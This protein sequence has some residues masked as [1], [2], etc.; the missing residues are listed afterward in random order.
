MKKQY[1]RLCSRCSGR[2]DNEKGGPYCLYPQGQPAR[3]LCGGCQM[4]GETELYLYERVADILIRRAIARR[5]TAAEKPD[6][7]AR[8]REKFRDW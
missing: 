1:I 4:Q 7:R 3:G 2:M 6:T 5:R 8:Y